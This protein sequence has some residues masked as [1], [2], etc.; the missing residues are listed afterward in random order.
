MGNLLGFGL[1]RLREAKDL[2]QFVIADGCGL[3]QSLVSKWETTG[4]LPSEYWQCVLETLSVRLDELRRAA[5]EAMSGRPVQS[6]EAVELWRDAVAFSDE[7]SSAAKV[8]LFKLTL[9]IDPELWL[10]MAGREDVTKSGAAWKAA[11]ESEFVQP[12]G[13][14]G[15][16]KLRF[17][18]E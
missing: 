1:K 14:G 9:H 15:A 3:S 13:S 16:F 10:V 5:V 8:V 12:I 2:K 11:V 4:D 7:L 18:E 17:P 6:Q